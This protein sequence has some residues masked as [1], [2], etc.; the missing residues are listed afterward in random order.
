MVTADRGTKTWLV[1]TLIPQHNTYLVTGQETG[2][3]AWQ[4]VQAGAEGVE[5]VA[6]GPFDVAE[7]EL[8]EATEVVEG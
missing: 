3:A 1:Q 6:T 4:A 8:I 7:E 5:W 2:L